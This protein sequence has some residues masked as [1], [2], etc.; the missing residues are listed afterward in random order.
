MALIGGIF[1]TVHGC[2]N[3]SP[4]VGFAGIMCSCIGYYIFKY[5][6]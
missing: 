4:V 6:R 1:M 2:N 5:M 3:T